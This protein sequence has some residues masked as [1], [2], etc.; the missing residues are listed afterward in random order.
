MVNIS[1]GAFFGESTPIISVF[2]SKNPV[3]VVHFL[4]SNVRGFLIVVIRVDNS[5][6]YFIGGK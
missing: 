6:I 5:I 3:D 2:I 1:E 4:S